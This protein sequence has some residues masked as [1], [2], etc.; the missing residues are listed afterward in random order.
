MLTRFALKH[1]WAPVGSPV[2]PREETVFLLNY[3][4]GGSAGLDVARRI[5][6]RVASLPGLEGLHIVEDALG[7]YGIS[8]ED[9]PALPP[10]GHQPGRTTARRDTALAGAS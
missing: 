5:D 7:T 9:D 4:M 6:R 1:A 10:A 8:S 3:L 2:M